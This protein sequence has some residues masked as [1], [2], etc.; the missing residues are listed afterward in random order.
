[1]FNKIQY[2]VLI[3]GICSLFMAIFMV[4]CVWMMG[5]FMDSSP[6][7]RRNLMVELNNG[8]P[9][10]IV[11]YEE[12]YINDDEY[13]FSGPVTIQMCCDKYGLDTEMVTEMFD[14]SKYDDFQVFFNKV[15]KKNYI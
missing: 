1:M 11:Y 7:N 10:A 12:N 3:A 9:E 6:I 15:L 14:N 13:I 2:A 8:N 4:I 5:H